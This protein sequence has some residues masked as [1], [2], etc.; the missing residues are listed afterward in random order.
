MSFAWFDYKE[1]DALG[2]SLA[3]ELAQRVPPATLADRTSWRPKDQAKLANALRD[4]FLKLQQFHRERRPGV[5]KRARLSKSF[6]DE[7]VALGYQE[8][9][10]R[11]VTLGAAEHLTQV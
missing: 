1:V 4:A 3:Q 6:Q 9:F 11:E 2:K 5:L 8:D 7:L 10:V